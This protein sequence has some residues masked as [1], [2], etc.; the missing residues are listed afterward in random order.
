M[1]TPHFRQLVGVITGRGYPG[2]WSSRV[3]R[4]IGANARPGY[5]GRTFDIVNQVDPVVVQAVAHTGFPGVF[6]RPPLARDE[7]IYGFE[8]RI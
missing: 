8:K 3:W 6:D 4:C 2:Y 7:H 1:P 5:C